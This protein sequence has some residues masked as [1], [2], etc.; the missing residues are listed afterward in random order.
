MADELLN[1]RNKPFG[2][3]TVYVDGVRY[4]TRTWLGRLRKHTFWT[5]DPDPDCHDHP[6][7]F[8]TFPLAPYVEEV[9]APKLA[10]MVRDNAEIFN[11][12]TICPSNSAVR[13]RQIVPAFRI[14]YRPGAHAHRVLGRASAGAAAQ[15]RQR[16]PDGVPDDLLYDPRP[17][18]T[19]V[20]RERLKVP[21][22]WGF[23]K[24]TDNRW[25]FDTA[26]KYIFKGG[27]N[28]PCE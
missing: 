25:C 7:G 13:Y 27:K 9:I 11:E 3:N 23:F 20:W 15:Y 26:V 16:V 21:R 6:E 24:N 5:G 19:L 17:V 4:M 14:T 12:S 22:D 8:Y 2:Q 1:T 28:A 18:T 10:V